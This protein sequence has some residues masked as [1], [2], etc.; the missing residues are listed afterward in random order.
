MG[1]PA[2]ARA[3]QEGRGAG[4]CGD[5]GICLARGVGFVGVLRVAQAEAGRGTAGQRRRKDHELAGGIQAK[6]GARRAASVK[7]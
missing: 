1:A 2:S 5:G 4:A 3:L 6:A 7:L